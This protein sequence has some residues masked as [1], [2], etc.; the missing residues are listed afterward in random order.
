[1]KPSYSSGFARGQKLVRY[2]IVGALI[3][4]LVGFLVYGSSPAQQTLCLLFSLV[5]MV[6]AVVCVFRFCR[7][8]RCGKVIIG[9]VLVLETCP[10][11]KCNLYS[12]EKSKKAKKK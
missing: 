3:M 4:G 2:L 9:G 1:M 7:C 6:S 8:P 12:G 5:M 10:R 11:C